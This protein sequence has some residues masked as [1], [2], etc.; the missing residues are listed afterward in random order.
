LNSQEV[1]SRQLSAWGLDLG[2][3]R[4][5][6]LLDYARLLSGYD[7]ANVIGTRDA[8]E[9]LRGHV[10]DSLSCLLFEPLRS[11][12]RVA[13]I[14]S[15]GGLPGIPLAV[16]LP[17]AEVTLFESVGKK[18]DF[19]HYACTE[20]SLGNVTVVNSRVE[21]AAREHEH[22]GG[23]AVCTARAL[24]RMAVI[25]EYSL[26]LLADGGH[27]LAMKGKRD[28]EEIAEV[29]RAAAVLG[30]RLSVE[31]PV[32]SVPELEQKERRL[33]VLEKV[34]ETPSRYPRRAGTPAKAPLGRKQ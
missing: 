18:A 7:R 4:E 5:T 16:A 1:F 27:T 28:E 9:I 24:A 11:A 20:L 15:G 13:D 3:S 32:H 10:L 33:L 2:S 12:G 6:L 25:A 14:G 17:Q 19:L 23:Y 21:E 30:G 34:G 31:I 8:D 22:S 29:R 26:P